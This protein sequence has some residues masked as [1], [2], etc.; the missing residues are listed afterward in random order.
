MT[1]ENDEK[2]QYFNREIPSKIPFEPKPEQ[3][4]PE[5]E[6]SAPVQPN[7]PAEA[8]HPVSTPK[9]IIDLRTISFEVDPMVAHKIQ[10]QMQDCGFAD[11]TQNR[12]ENPRFAQTINTNITKLFY[13]YIIYKVRMRENLNI[14]IKGE[15]RS[16]KSTAALSIGSFISSMTRIPYTPYHICANESECSPYDIASAG[17]PEILHEG[18]ECEVR[19]ALP[20]RR[21][22]RVQ[23]RRRV[24][25]KLKAEHRG[26]G[27][28]GLNSLEARVPRNPEMRQDT[29]V[30]L[31]H[32]SQAMLDFRHGNFRAGQI[33]IPL[34]D[35]APA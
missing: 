26:D 12:P 18:Q 15:T 32:Y 35:E 33:L 11:S 8:V 29:P 9:R 25:Q 17:Q 4:K 22:K 5:P 14:A 1:E 6:Q 16:G 28:Y 19:R 13:D 31:V 10:M 30:P 20:H 7:I 23:V 34:R 3:V 2:T 27:D 24:V 21:A